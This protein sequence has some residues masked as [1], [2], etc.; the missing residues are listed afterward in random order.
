MAGDG[1]GCWA[2]WR[3]ENDR[4]ARRWRRVRGRGREG[5]RGRG[6]RA[7][8]L[9]GLRRSLV[10]PLQAAPS[11]GPAPPQQFAELLRKIQ[12]LPAVLPSLSL[13]LTILCNALPFEM[14]PPGG[15]PQRASAWIERG[16][17]RVLEAFAAPEE[18]LDCGEL[19]PRVLQQA[20][21][22]ELRAP[23]QHL[24][25]LQAA[26]WLAGHQLERARDLLLLLN[27]AQIPDPSCV[28]CDSELLSLLQM[29]H[30]HE[31]GESDPLVVQT[32]TD[33]KETLWTSAAFLQGVQELEADNPHHALVLLQAAASGLC[34]KRVLAQIFTLM[35]SCYRKI[36]LYGEKQI[37]NPLTL[38]NL[39]GKP[40]TALHHL[41]QA[42]E[43]DSTFLP[44]LYQAALVY[45]Q[46]ELTEAELE[47]LLLLCQ[48][49][50]SPPQVTLESHNLHFLIRTELL[51][52]GC[53]PAAFLAPSCPS[54][55]KYM[56]AKRCLQAKRA[57]EAAE[58]YLDLLALFQ[59]GLLPQVSQCSE[60]AMPRI[61]EVFLEAASALEEAA[62]HQEA[63]MVCEEVVSR[64]S[65]LIPARLRIVLD[66]SSEEKAIGAERS[67]LAKSPAAVLEE[68]RESLR[69]VLWQAAAH[70]IQGWARARLRET[71][72]AI[73]SFSRCLNDLLRVHL[74]S[75]G[76]DRGNCRTEPEREKTAIPEG[77]QLPQTRLLALTGRGIQFLEL[78][79]FKQ[80]LMDF[81]YSLQVSPG[82]F[83]TKFLLLK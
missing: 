38:L 20:A 75:T 2:L 22:E 49:L 6:R 52:S 10:L 76:M 54:G 53:H 60:L 68:Q 78:G 82:T 81:Q 44:A 70:L 17:R 57:T 42:L 63:I 83:S 73:N 40:H 39:Q 65:R 11:P 24:A 69:C 50:E 79:K 26:S 25:A 67:P 4:L 47:A 74:V 21:P 61:P 64:V 58:H 41:K 36:T 7:L 59:E 23:L 34:S 5:G 37:L 48:A 51:T 45:H 55:V 80:A 12:G 28:G 56:L 30:P 16:L 8:G 29:W 19:W 27:G 1:D 9:V 3:A 18:G 62:R 43:M 15:G 46:L 32:I 71:K 35:G 14:R 72:E 66:L 13:E 33:L 77:E 31:M